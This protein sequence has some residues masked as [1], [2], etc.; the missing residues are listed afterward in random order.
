[1]SEAYDPSAE[2]AQMSFK[3]RM[4]Y[5]DYLHLE[6]VLDAQE[7]LSTAHDEMPGSVR[8]SSGG[9]AS[10]GCPPVWS[11]TRPSRRNTTRS[12]HDANRG[13]WVT[14]TIA[15]PVVS[16]TCASSSMT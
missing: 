11:T 13:S 10:S 14:S 6:K 8:A 9:S 7:P 16:D 3:G 5:S 2:G 12:A 1:M 4:S 15:A